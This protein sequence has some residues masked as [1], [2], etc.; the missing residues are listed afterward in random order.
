MIADLKETYTIEKSI[1]IN[2]TSE[3]KHISSKSI[4]PI[5]LIFNELIS[6]SIKHAFEHLE[7]G[8]IEVLVSA[9]KDKGKI[10]LIYKDNGKW[11]ESESN[12]FGMELIET[13]TEQL[14]GT[15]SIIKK[16]KTEFTFSLKV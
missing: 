4:V 2:I 5:S 10:T 16:D 8:K 9:H 1:D 14:D 13:M 15:I 7:K 3:I 11:K 6:N 12:S